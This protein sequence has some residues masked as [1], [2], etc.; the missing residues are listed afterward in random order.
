M[1]VTA[2][3][4]IDTLP[5]AN[6]GTVDLTSTSFG[7]VDAAI[8]FLNTA[9]TTNNPQADSA[10]GIAFWDGTNDSSCSAFSEDGLTTSNTDRDWETG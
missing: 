7:T 5:Q 4:D 6:S 2:F 8:V 10:P 9:N 3:V 1:P